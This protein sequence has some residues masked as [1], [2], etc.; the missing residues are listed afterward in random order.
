MMIDTHD[1]DHEKVL[2]RGELFAAP[3]NGVAG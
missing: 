3:D 1:H 2:D